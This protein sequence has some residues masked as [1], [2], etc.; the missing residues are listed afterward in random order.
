M[1]VYDDMAQIHTHHNE[2][3][4]NALT[5]AAFAHL[6]SILAEMIYLDFVVASNITSARCCPFYMRKKTQNIKK[7]YNI[8]HEKL[9]IPHQRHSK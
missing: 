5:L 9:G 2:N 6:P 7:I 1:C 3:S 8:N 4:K